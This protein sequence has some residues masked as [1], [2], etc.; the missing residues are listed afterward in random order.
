MNRNHV[1]MLTITLAVAALAVGYS[2][3]QNATPMPAPMPGTGAA[4]MAPGMMHPELGMRP[5][6]PM[7]EMPE[8]EKM[9][10]FM[11]VVQQMSEICKDPTAA[12]M[13]AVGGLKDDVKRD[14]AE[15]ITD[16]EQ[17]LEK[18][19]ALPIRNAIRLTL[20][21]LYKEN[22]NN[23]KVLA[24]LHAMVAENDAAA[25]PSPRPVPAGEGRGE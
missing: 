3:A 12:G 23:E 10:M 9:M 11:R 16:L 14:R 6:R 20:K 7:G 2:L 4:P 8:I 22:G 15:V 17:T 13:L 25:R 5:A 1:L 18:T 21:D 19:R 24:Q